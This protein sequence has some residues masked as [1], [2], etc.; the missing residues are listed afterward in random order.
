M[1]RSTLA[2]VALTSTLLATAGL[3]T[4]Q[5]AD[6]YPVVAAKAPAAARQH[7]INVSPLGLIGGGFNANYEYLSRGHHGLLLEIG[8]GAWVNNHASSRNGVMVSETETDGRHGT[9]GVGYRYHLRGRQH[10]MFLGVVLHHNVGTAS[11]RSTKNGQTVAGK[12]IA[13]ESSTVTAHVG[14]R[15]MLTDGLN[16]TARL[17]F[18]SA[19]RTVTDEDADPMAAAALQDSIDVPVAIDG[20]LSLG[21]TF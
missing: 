16:L 18:G 8:S 15:W 9:V 17:G 6:V 12:D 2:A 20:E 21:W 3:A 13:Y 19:E 1:T 4:A 11:V 10:G 5:P 14:K 7:S